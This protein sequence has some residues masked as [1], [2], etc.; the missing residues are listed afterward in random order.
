MEQKHFILYYTTAYLL[1]CL[2]FQI[3]CIHNLRLIADYSWSYF[4]HM[5]YLVSMLFF[6]NLLIIHWL[7]PKYKKAHNYKK[8]SLQLLLLF[9]FYVFIFYSNRW[10]LERLPAHFLGTSVNSEF[11]KPKGNLLYF[12]TSIVQMTPLAIWI[13]CLFLIVIPFQRYIERQKLYLKSKSAFNASR[14]S[15]LRMKMNPH[16]LFNELNNIHSLS[17]LD[18]DRYYSYV[19]N[20][21]NLSKLILSEAKA[22]TIPLADELDAV[23]KY[24]TL[25]QIRYGSKLNV[26]YERFELSQDGYIPHI[27]LITLVENAVKHCSLNRAMNGYHISIEMKEEN[28]RFYFFCDNTFDPNVIVEKGIGLKQLYERLSIYYD[29][30]FTLSKK[31]NDEIYQVILK[32]PLHAR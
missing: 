11:L 4:T 24:L 5:L 18:D 26:K 22:M 10:V 19:S 9:G 16:F 29:D 25:Q 15:L 1:A 32:I 2:T 12:E 14:M 6:L 31:V 20:S 30:S 13:S 17:I 27:T 23:Y 8:L 21:I 28:G 3:V 7:Y